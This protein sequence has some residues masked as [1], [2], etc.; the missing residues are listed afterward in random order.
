[1]SFAE[2]M[3]NG[4]D[5]VYK[6]SSDNTRSYYEIKEFLDKVAQAMKEYTKNM[7]KIVDEFRK[8]RLTCQQPMY[9]GT[10][11][12][13]IES[14]LDGIEQEVNGQLQMS[15]II[16]ETSKE[17]E[18][19]IKA[20]EK[21]NKAL[22]DEGIRQTKEYNNQKSLLNKTKEQY[23]KLAKD[24]EQTEYSY[25]AAQQDSKKQSKLPQMKVKLD[26]T[27]QKAQD[28]EKS[29]VDCLDKTNTMTLQYYNEFQPSLLNKFQTNEENGI[30]T[31]KTLLLSITKSYCAL[32]DKFN[33]FVDCI[34]V[35]FT[36]VCCY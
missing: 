28:A 31:L 12:K 35:G 6:Y 4:L 32:P 15:Q 25:N 11:R 24:Y 30:N 29:Y 7:N 33:R 13:A 20:L 5:K 26:A 3:I 34:Q 22:T 36:C 8:K 10:V 16:T 23:F 1:M 14:Y 18:M 19:N 17:Y 2:N 21:E 9:K 27:K